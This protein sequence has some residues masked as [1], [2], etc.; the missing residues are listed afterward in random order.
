MFEL[1]ER[2]MTADGLRLAA[3]GPTRIGHVSPRLHVK[4]RKSEV[5]STDY[6]DLRKISLVVS[7]T[8]TLVCVNL[9]YKRAGSSF[10]RRCHSEERSDEES[11]LSTGQSL[12]KLA[13]GVEIPRCARNDSR[14][15]ILTFAF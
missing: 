1:V 5:E 7:G 3:Y 13:E 12:P 6:T 14:S 4:R 8:P 9:Y 10:S 2:M 11:R 15:G